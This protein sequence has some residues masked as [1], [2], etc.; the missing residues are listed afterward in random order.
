[1]SKVHRILETDCLSNP[2]LTTETLCHRE[3]KAE[4]DEFGLLKNFT[5]LRTGQPLKVVWTDQ[6][7]CNTCRHV[8]KNIR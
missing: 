5:S 3:V 8:W 7:D 2:G 1:M 6:F 4:R